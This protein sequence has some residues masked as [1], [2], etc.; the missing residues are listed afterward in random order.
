MPSPA[1][2]VTALK[3]SAP[4]ARELLG[5]LAQAL[6]EWGASKG[7]EIEL[8]L[9]DCRLPARATLQEDDL[10]L[11]VQVATIEGDEPV[12]LRIVPLEPPEQWPIVISDWLA[13]RN[14]LLASEEKLSPDVADR[15]G[16]IVTSGTFNALALKAWNPASLRCEGQ[17]LPVAGQTELLI[18]ALQERAMVPVWHAE[19][20][21]RLLT[22]PG[23]LAPRHPDLHALD[24]SLLL[25]DQ[26][27]LLQAWVQRTGELVD[28]GAAFTPP[29]IL[30]FHG[31][32]GSGK[33][34]TIRLLSRYLG[35]P[36]ISVEGIAGSFP[37]SAE[38]FRRAFRRAEEYGGLLLIED[39]EAFAPKQPLDTAGA[40]LRQTFLSVLDSFSGL[41][42]A[43]TN[44]VREVAPAFVSRCGMRLALQ[45][46]DQ[47]SKE[48]ASVVW[49]RLFTANG[50]EAKEDLLEL[51][52]G[53]G[54]PPRAVMHI[55]GLI[56][57]MDP[58]KTLTAADLQEIQYAAD[59]AANAAEPDDGDAGTEPA[60]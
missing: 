7:V 30:L 31:P 57:A 16:Q 18:R 55:T 45:P 27:S 28:P 26:Q 34:W 49:K 41:V 15:L 33:S 20:G 59:L 3:S 11:M 38:T 23:L 29:T 6:P 60:P 24:A 9:D 19:T 4:D 2:H 56:R 32:P 51:L 5:V 36:I 50:L 14:V 53:T 1:F 12:P 22:L 21:E 40:L 47:L 25:D 43:T 54:A 37:P 58:D 13:Q 10:C 46:L 17:H 44:E 42:V 52:A 39:V 35:C 48:V 8:L